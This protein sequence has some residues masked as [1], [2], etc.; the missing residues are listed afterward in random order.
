MGV[1][2]TIGFLPYKVSD[3]AKVVMFLVGFC[4]TFLLSLKSQ[5]VPWKLVLQ[6][7]AMLITSFC[8]PVTWPIQASK[9]HHYHA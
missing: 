8:Y 1:G 3:C 6:S 5:A 4:S 7:Q 9:L 2:V